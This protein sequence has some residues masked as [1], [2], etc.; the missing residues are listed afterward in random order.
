M[1]AGTTRRTG[2]LGQLSAGLKLFPFCLFLLPFYSIF[3]PLGT[4]PFIAQDL[5]SPPPSAPASTLSFFHDPGCC[6]E[7]T[8][9]AGRRKV[10]LNLPKLPHRSR[11]L[12]LKIYI[13]T[14]TVLIFPGICWTSVGHASEGKKYETILNC[15]ATCLSRS[16]VHPFRWLGLPP[17]AYS[18]N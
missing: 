9:P 4:K 16:H 3:P 14:E 13:Y 5:L 17:T 1:G 11:H 7:P 10:F 6:T 18:S 8:S 12:G 15:V 2:R